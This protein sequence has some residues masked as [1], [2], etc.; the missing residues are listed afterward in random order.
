MNERRGEESVTVVFD[1][2]GPRAYDESGNEVEVPAIYLHAHVT[3]H[4]VAL[5]KGEELHCAD[6]GFPN[7]PPKVYSSQ[8]VSS[9]E[10]IKASDGHLLLEMYSTALRQVVEAGNAGG[11]MLD[12]NLT[13][14]VIV[15]TRS[16]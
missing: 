13:V 10:R 8:Q 9:A 5:T 2:S 3:G 6:C 16:L 7:Y 1:P 15:E 12:P 4:T 11:D 14:K